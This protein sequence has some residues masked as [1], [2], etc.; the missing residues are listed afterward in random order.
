MPSPKK[1]SSEISKAFLK[2]R[3]CIFALQM[4]MASKLWGISFKSKKETDN[5]TVKLSVLS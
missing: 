3:A 4:L 5:T 2:K 1:E